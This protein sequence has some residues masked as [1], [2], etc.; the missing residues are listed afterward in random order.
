MLAGH[1]LAAAPACVLLVPA[2]APVAQL[3]IGRRNAT[4]LRWRNSVAMRERK[5]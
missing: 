1:A 3:R 4:A 5:A 2:D